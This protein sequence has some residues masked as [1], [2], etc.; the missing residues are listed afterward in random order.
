[1]KIAVVGSRDFDDYEFLK[2]ILSYHPCTKIISGGADG[3]DTLAKQYATEHGLGYQE[4]LP[5]WDAYGKPAGYLRNKQIVDASDELVAFWNK[6]SPGTKSSIDLANEA[7]KPVYIYW[8]P[9]PD[10]MEGIGV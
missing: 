2:K 4:F 8:P 6:I 10:I 1:M 3:A 7:D 9:E 5:N